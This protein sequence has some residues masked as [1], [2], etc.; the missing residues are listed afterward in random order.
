MHCT[1]GH[2]RSP[3]P[4]MPDP[5]H[6]LLSYR[7]VKRIALDE[8]QVHSRLSLTYTKTLASRS[9][10]CPS[11]F[12]GAKLGPPSSQYFLR[13]SRCR[14]LV[15]DIESAEQHLLFSGKTW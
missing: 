11:A 4:N 1:K 6:E 8:P 9:D 12:V 14:L 5:T 2:R 13:G 3:L 10:T 7:R 15:D